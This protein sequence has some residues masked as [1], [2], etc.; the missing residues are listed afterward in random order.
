MSSAPAA[1]GASVL[2]AW[3]EA[4]QVDATVCA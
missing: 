3:I 4:F 2:A 1:T